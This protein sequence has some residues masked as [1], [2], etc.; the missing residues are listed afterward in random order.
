[1]G[2][3]G[4]AKERIIR[5]SY[6]R[7]VLVS[8]IVIGATNLCGF[9]DNIVISRF[10]GT[11]SLAA[12]GF[13]SPVTFITG[14][15]YVVVLGTTMLA[16]NLIGAGKRNEVN[17]LFTGAFIIILSLITLLVVILIVFRSGVSD[18]LGAR[19][20]ADVLLEDYILGFAPG[21]IF[22]SLAALLLSLAS[23]NNA[24]RTSYAATAVMFVGNVA[25]DIILA[26]PMGIFGIGLASTVSSLAMFAVLIPVFVDKRSTIHFVP[27]RP[28]MKPVTEAIR[29]GMPSLSLAA[30]V[31]VKNSLLN[32]SL[33]RYAG[34]DGIAVVNVLAS[35][36]SMTGSFLGGFAGGHAALASLY[37]GEEER[38]GFMKLFR[39]A[40]RLGVVC[41]TLMA[42][43]FSVFAEPLAG[44]FFTP[45]TPVF[46]LG[47][48]MLLLG[49]WFLPLN[50]FFNI[51]LN[52]YKVQNRM[53]P[54]NILSFAE[55]GSIGVIALLAMP[56]L[57]TDAAWLANTASDIVCVIILCALTLYLNRHAGSFADR[58]MNLPRDFGAA[59]EKVFERG[60]TNKQEAILA[61]EAVVA[62]CRRCGVDNRRANLSGLCVEELTRNILEHGG[63]DEKK[64]NLDVRVACK[65]E[66]VIRIQDDCV[67]FDPSERMKLY[68]PAN[69]EEN[70]GLRL[71]GRIA[72][73]TEYYNNAGIN[74]LLIR[75]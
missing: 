12:V 28:D 26:K 64:K 40:C 44:I 10:L 20:S 51:L 11:E 60:I 62:L 43:A 29:R 46:L 5:E 3:A 68:A 36:C 74:T 39:Y 13:F 27:R 58:I 72:A 7:V 16:G 71:V 67:K 22:S 31:L 24:I 37:F 25:A 35:I 73:T 19:G 69:P 14:L 1:M 2:K 17:V 57:G 42:A 15:S 49:F 52:T 8:I 21:M 23:F 61:S 30:G 65:E 63:F 33:V 4:E 32:Y 75:L 56:V 45:G 66:V 34:N 70:I 38:E 41:M 54:A 53:K 55:T 9:I 6:L 48:R 47:C 50:V 18:I 59:P